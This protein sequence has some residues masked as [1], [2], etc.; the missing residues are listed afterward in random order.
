MSVGD[1]WSSKAVQPLLPNVPKE[2]E[3]LD[4]KA[5]MPHV[6]LTDTLWTAFAT[7]SNGLKAI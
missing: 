4:T 3:V 6:E 2:M 1:A 5:S 7:L